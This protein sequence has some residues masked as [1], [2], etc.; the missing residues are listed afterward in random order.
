MYLSKFNFY[1]SLIVPP[2]LVLFPATKLDDDAF[3]A[4]FGGEIVN[5][6][7]RKTMSLLKDNKN[8]RYYLTKIIPFKKV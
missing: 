3:S 4:Y 5:P 8:C 7:V 2:F 6:V 1:S